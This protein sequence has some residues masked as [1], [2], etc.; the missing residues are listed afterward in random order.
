MPDTERSARLSTCPIIIIYTSPGLLN[1][2]PQLAEIVI[3][4]NG[5][6]SEIVLIGDGLRE[7]AA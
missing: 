4:A 7:I 1:S 3:K 6:S 2:I 5:I